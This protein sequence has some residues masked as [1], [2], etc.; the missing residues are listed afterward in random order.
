MYATKDEDRVE[1]SLNDFIRCTLGQTWYI[2]VTVSYREG[3]KP[4][5]VD[6]NML[7]FPLFSTG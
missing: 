3:K 1:H 4:S 6:L 5:D 2:F 7:Y